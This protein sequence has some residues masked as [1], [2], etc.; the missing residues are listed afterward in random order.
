MLRLTLFEL[1]KLWT[2]RSF[3]LAVCV[4]LLIHIFLLWYTYLPDEETPPLSSYKK[5]HM[6]LSCMS[7]AEKADYIARQKETIDGVCFVRDILAM[8]GFQNEMGDVLA[9]QEMQNNPGRFETYYDVYQSGSYLKFTDSLEQEKTFIDE[10][11]DEQQRVAGYG[12]YLRSI[13]AN[14][15]MLSGISIFSEGDSEG[16][17]TRNIDKSAADYANLTDAN[18]RFFPSK[19]IIIA[20]ESI[21]TD[22][23][24]LLCVMLFVGGLITEEKEK[25]L[26]LVTRG[27]KYGILHDITAKLGALFIHCI[28]LTILFYLVNL[29]FAGENVG[30]FHPEVSLQSVAAYTQSSLSVS[31]LGYIVLSILTKAFVLFGIGSLLAAFCIVCDVAVLPYLAWMG[32]VGISMLLYLIVPADSVFS[33]CKYLNPIGLLKTENLY[34]GY[35]NFNLFGYPV[36]RLRLS[37][38]LILL[39]CVIGILG[40]LLLFARMQSFEIRK[41]RLSFSLPF[42]PHINIWRHEG[43]KLLI[44]NRG[45]V[46]LLL[47]ALLLALRSTNRT[48]TPS[49]IEQYYRDIMKE[50]EGEYTKEK[51]SLIISE[52]K[53]YE[54]AFEKID[55]INEME[56]SGEIDDVA[57]DELRTR[58]NMTLSFY[59]AFSRVEKQYQHIKE[60]GGAFVYDTGY[61]YLLGVWEDAFSVDFLIL[62][63]GIILVA[64]SAVSMEYQTGTLFLLCATKTGWRKIL[65]RKY[66]ICMGAAAGLALVP[67]ICRSCCI[68]SVYPMH[69]FSTAIQ[70][71]PYYSEFVVSLPIGIFIL[72]FI[73]SQMAVAVLIV[74][75]TLGLSLWRKNQVQ[76][77]F[78]SLLF[79]T[80]P[81]ILKQLGF[82]IAKW[83]SLYPLYGWTGII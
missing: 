70:N 50:L 23:L 33:V 17:S 36:S 20:M 27:T 31:L 8:Q 73:F 68:A 39:L 35:L 19:G 57:A 32:I 29:V 46:L 55:E 34:G 30:W 76:T 58:I 12:E 16:F 2:K 7:E 18:I 26:F 75:I 81:I 22:L 1:N 66:M 63:I 42:K 78:F 4:L 72:L 14:K 6:Q 37:L 49:V 25:K 52:K 65:A 60:Y 3:V 54:E 44:T 61:L 69:G 62:S 13:Q 41:L 53:R 21:W 10:I 15:D 48:Y 5:I 43:Y 79:L 82:E 71:I 77:I 45:L 80:V 74:V 51:E 28:L 11:Y 40:S 67:V 56:S 64:S 83:F 38:M 47:V 59:P 9:E 24:L